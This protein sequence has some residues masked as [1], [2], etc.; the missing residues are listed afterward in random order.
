MTGQLFEK[1]ALHYQ[2]NLPF[3]VYRKP[4]GALVR[5]I[6]QE[7]G[8]LRHMN[9]FHGPGFVFAHFDAKRPAVL[10]S[11]D[12]I[13]E[14]SYLALPNTPIPPKNITANS[15]QKATHMAL[16]QKGI[17]AIHA[18]KFKKVVLS[19]RMEMNLKTAPIAVFK[20]LLMQY[21]TAFCYLWHHPEI[22]TWMGAT[23]ELL[24]KIE[25]KALTAMA[26]AGTQPF[27]GTTKVVWGTKEREEQQL[28]TD[29][30][31]SALTGKV[32]DLCVSP[33][34]SIRAGDLLHLR[35]SITG[36][37]AITGLQDLVSVLHPTPA[38]CGLPMASAKA[39]I[40][41]NENYDREYYTGYLGELNLMQGQIGA[42]FTANGEN[43]THMGTRLYVNLRCMQLVGEKIFVY[44]GGG[45][46]KDSDPEKEWQETVAKSGTM[47]HVLGMDP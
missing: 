39:F 13:M 45:I 34:E 16:V 24:L 7:S 15:E 30:I 36:T 2:K 38:V 41:E 47:G 1:V 23:P 11:P 17:D 18:N 31:V 37:M 12:I 46:T 25:N 40:L 44:V 35:S 6:F 22:G 43:G 27:L 28:V 21:P 5:A 26:L 9:N 4:D 8:E 10:I 42:S 20:A 3:V 19:R 32:A 14:S 33:V 29:H